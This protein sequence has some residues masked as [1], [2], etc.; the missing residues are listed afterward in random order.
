MTTEF[1]QY[2]SEQGDAF[3]DN[4]RWSWPSRASAESCGVWILPDFHMKLLVAV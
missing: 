1:G 2:E 3:H 4:T